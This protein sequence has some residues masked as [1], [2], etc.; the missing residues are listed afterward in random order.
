MTNESTEQTKTRH[1]GLSAEYIL[2][3]SLCREPH[4]A[5]EPNWK[6]RA[7]SEIEN[8]D[9]APAYAES[10]YTQPDRGILFANWNYF[11]R[12]IGDVLERAGYAIEW[13]DEWTRCDNCNKAIRTSADCYD[14]QPSYVWLHDCPVCV[15]CL[16]GDASEWLESMEDNPKRAVNVPQVDMAKWG[17][18]KIQG[19]FESGF[20]PGQ[21][22]NPESIYDKLVAD[23]HKRIVFRIDEVSQFYTVFSVWKY[24]DAGEPVDPHAEVE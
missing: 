1:S 18:V 5:S 9:F 21:T 14:W 15:T 11:P 16:N 8:M 13:S 20:H 24:N 22:D 23:G 6:Q 19:Q 17:Y 7:E 10:G 12:D 4:C 3:A 2:R